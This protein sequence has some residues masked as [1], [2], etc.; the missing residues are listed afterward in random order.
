MERRTTLLAIV[1][2]AALG[3]LMLAGHNNAETRPGEESIES[4][5]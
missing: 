2:S 4:P 3:G 5:G 1:T